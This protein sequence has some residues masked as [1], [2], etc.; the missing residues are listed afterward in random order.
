MPP[1][2]RRANFDLGQACGVDCVVGRRP[3]ETQH[4]SR[5]GFSDEALGERAAV[6]K[7]GRHTHLDS[8]SDALTNDLFGQG[9]AF[10][11]RRLVF[12]ELFVGHRARWDVRE[13]TLGQASP[14]RTHARAGRRHQRSTPRLSTSLAEAVRPARVVRKRAAFESLGEFHFQ[15]SW[16]TSPTQPGCKLLRTANSVKQLATTLNSEVEHPEEEQ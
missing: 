10:D 15:T 8:A 2:E 7:V 5:A 14:I 16:F 9:F 12:V 6:E 13:E 11:L 1:R 3:P 4:E